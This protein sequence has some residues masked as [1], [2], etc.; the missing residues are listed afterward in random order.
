MGTEELVAAGDLADVDGHNADGT[1]AL[2]AG[3]VAA[4]LAEFRLVFV[5]S[6]VAYELEPWLFRLIGI[7][8][9]YRRHVLVST[10]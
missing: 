1:G 2:N 8:Y 5:E 4:K 3:D 7:S 6:L 10:N 9:I